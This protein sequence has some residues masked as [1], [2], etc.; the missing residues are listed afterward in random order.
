[1]ENLPKLSDALKA[2]GLWANKSLGQHFLLDANLCGRIAALS[3]GLQGKNIVEVGP[4]PGGL[5]RAIVAME[6]QSFTMV[7]M[8]KRFEAVLSPLT[9]I[10]N[11]TQIL[12]GDALKTPIHTL[13]DGKITLLSNLPYNIGSV[14]L[15]NWLK[16][17]EAFDQFVLMFQKEVAQRVCANPNDKHYGRLA[18]MT[19]WLCHTHMALHVPPAAFT[20]PPKVDS[21]VIVI[22]PREK[23]LMDIDFATMELTVAKAFGMRRKMLKR[24][25]KGIDI[26]W[27]ELGIDASQRPENLEVTDFCKIAIAYKKSLAMP[28][29]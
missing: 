4:G 3:G 16:N 18:V 2:E 12:W 17:I 19:N 14:L 10:H 20:P 15:I 27:Q 22:T 6:P 25:F 9:H 26:P 13:Y 24:I 28:S 29:K 21:A 23:P 8:D 1:M 5:S 11:N 7:E